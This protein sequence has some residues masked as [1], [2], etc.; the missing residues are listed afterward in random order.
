MEPDEITEMADAL[1][2]GFE[3]VANDPVTW[4]DSGDKETDLL[5]QL[6]DLL[7][8]S[9]TAKVLEGVQ[10]DQAGWRSG[11]LRK[12]TFTKR[13]LA[14]K[15]VALDPSGHFVIADERW[16]ICDGEPIL[17]ALVPLA[18]IQNLVQVVIRRSVELNNTV[19]GTEFTYG[20]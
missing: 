20:E 12:A 19:P 15:Q 14:E 11:A 5:C 13:R 10:S 4:V 18:G 1:D 9:T 8:P 7:I 17:E 6:E 16:D 2:E 3:L